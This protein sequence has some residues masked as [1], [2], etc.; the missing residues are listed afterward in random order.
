MGPPALAAGRWLELGA[1]DL[2]RSLRSLR[3][4]RQAYRRA[5]GE[6]Q[7]GFSRGEAIF[8]VHGREIRCD[9]TGDWPG[10]ARCGLRQALA[11]LT[12]EPDGPSARLLFSDGRLR[13]R[14]LSIP[15]A[16]V[17]S[18][19]LVAEISMQAHFQQLLS[20]TPRMRCPAC[21]RRSGVRL[22]DLEQHSALGPIQV[23]LA[24]L[25]TGG[26]ATHGCEACG[27]GWAALIDPTP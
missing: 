18:S 26:D 3:P 12:F 16:F 5:G 2:R 7:L 22:E 24:M 13:F 6:L 21:G 25:A 4:S 8:C 1:D 15:A 14:T 10:L 19:A 23:R 9:A 17:R 20:G 27:H 11:F